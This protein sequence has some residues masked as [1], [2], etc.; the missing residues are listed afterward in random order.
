MAWLK[1]G[2]SAY[3]MGL[4]AYVAHKLIYKKYP[5]YFKRTEITTLCGINGFFEFLV[6]MLYD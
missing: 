6:W 5:I 3:G 2:F 4:G 1:V